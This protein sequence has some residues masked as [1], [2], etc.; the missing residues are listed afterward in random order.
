MRTSVEMSPSLTQNRRAT[1]GSYGGEVRWP[2]QPL[3]P[4]G[5]VAGLVYR[6]GVSPMPQ[7]GDRHP[8]FIVEPMRC[9][10]MVC[11]GTMQAEA[12]SGRTGRTVVQLQ[13]RPLVAC[14]ELP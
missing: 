9:W 12:R 2:T 4:R 5:W 10:A 3:S 6:H 7:P 14:L 11:D 1:H 8:G 13:G